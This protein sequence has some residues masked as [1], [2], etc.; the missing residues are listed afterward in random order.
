M[1]SPGIVLR[2]EEARTGADL[3]DLVRRKSWVTRAGRRE[4]I[5]S[6]VCHLCTGASDYVTGQNFVVDGGRS[7]G[8]KG[9]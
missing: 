9:G 5:A 4:D 8:L 1:V 3:E 6:M 7:L 2:P